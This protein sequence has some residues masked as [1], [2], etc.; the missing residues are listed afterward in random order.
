MPP[1]TIPDIVRWR[2]HRRFHCYHRWPSTRPHRSMFWRQKRLDFEP[3]KKLWSHQKLFWMNKPS[4]P[5]SQARKSLGIMRSLDPQTATSPALPK[6]MRSKPKALFFSRQD[7][8]GISERRKHLDDAFLVKNPSATGSCT[9]PRE[10]FP[11]AVDTPPDRTPN[12]QPNRE[13]PPRVCCACCND[14]S[15]H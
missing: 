9:P 13:S 3:N 10:L 8:N 7:T 4:P 1:S 11:D 14:G 6:D 5:Q 15:P 12:Q 2:R